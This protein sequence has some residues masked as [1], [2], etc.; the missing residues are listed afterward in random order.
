MMSMIR[1]T[2]NIF[3]LVSLILLMATAV[4]WVTR[5]FSSKSRTLQVVRVPLHRTSSGEYSGYY[6]IQAISVGVNFVR[7]EMLPMPLSSPPMRRDGSVTPAMKAWREEVEMSDYRLPGLI[8]WRIPG[9]SGRNTE[10]IEVLHSWTYAVSVRYY[11]LVLL[12]ALLPAIWTVF[13]LRRRR[14]AYRVSKGLCR[15]CGYDLRASKEQC[16][17]CGTAIPADS[18]VGCEPKV[19]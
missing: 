8:L 4:L 1:R 11:I 3:A 16:P 7:Q 13:H 12:F 5:Q 15:E 10:R 9:V 17:E 18:A 14:N 6:E 19:V 2:S